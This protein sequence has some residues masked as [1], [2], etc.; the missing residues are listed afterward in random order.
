MVPR[1]AM[2]GKLASEVGSTPRGLAGAARCSS[3]AHNRSRRT[4][5]LRP[6]PEF[7]G[8]QDRSSNRRWG[9][10]CIHENALLLVDGLD[11]GR[12][13][14]AAGLADGELEVRDLRG[15]AVL[16]SF[17]AAIQA[18]LASRWFRA[19]HDVCFSASRFETNFMLL[20]SGSAATMLPIF[21]SCACV[22]VF[23]HPGARSVQ[24]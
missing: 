21:A 23:V 20:T 18:L 4:R 19:T 5:E 1:P 13:E 7:C 12:A 22:A 9:V 17:S 2:R 8:A 6:A 3:S 24:K 15:P 10:P 14:D 16:L 11:N